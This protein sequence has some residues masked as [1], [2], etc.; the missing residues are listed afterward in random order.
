MVF[1]SNHPGRVRF[2]GAVR[3]LRDANASRTCRSAEPGSYH[4]PEPRTAP[5]L[6]RTASQGLRAA[7]R[8]GN[9]GFKLCLPLPLAHSGDM[10]SAT[11]AKLRGNIMAIDF[12]IPAEAKAIR[13]KVRQWVHDECIPT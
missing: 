4:T 8:P 11:K 10:P 5:A 7:L 9:E 1:F 3:H 13:E 2:P 6:Q 12:E